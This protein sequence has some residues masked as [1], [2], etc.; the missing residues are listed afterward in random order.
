MM[1]K[2]LRSS[3]DISSLKSLELNKYY[4]KQFYLLVV[5]TRKKFA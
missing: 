1:F 3:T 4:L 2:E 5:H